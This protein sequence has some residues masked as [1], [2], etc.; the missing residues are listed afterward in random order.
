MF[1][2]DFSMMKSVIFLVPCI[3]YLFPYSFFLFHN[4][5]LTAHSEISV[6]VIDLLPNWPYISQST[7]LHV[8]FCC[9]QI[10]HLI[11]FCLFMRYRSCC[12]A[13]AGLE[14]LDSGNIS[15]QFLSIWGSQKPI[16][17]PEAVCDRSGEMGGSQ[18]EKRMKA[19]KISKER[20]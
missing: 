4:V 17:R 2:C 1:E 6:N 10:V 9:L 12:V 20:K 14:P 16:I 18:K 13:Q 7:E 5:L 11:I 15:F 8:Y 3:I 19:S